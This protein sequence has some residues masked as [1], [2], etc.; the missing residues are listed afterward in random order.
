MIVLY[1][2]AHMHTRTQPRKRAHRLNAP[3]HA[4][5][6]ARTHARI[7]NAR[8][9][10][11]SYIHARAFEAAHKPAHAHS[12]TNTPPKAPQQPS[13]TDERHHNS[14]SRS[15][16]CRARLKCP[17]IDQ[18]R[19]PACF[20]CHRSRAEHGYEEK[21]SGRVQPADP[22]S[23]LGRVLT[24][25]GNSGILAQKVLE[26]LQGSRRHTLLSFT[27]GM[28]RQPNSAVC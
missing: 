11:C 1:V 19:H 8:T 17:G 22:K 16:N 5:M 18:G 9:H 7:Q 27:P 26:S 4:C 23:N 25:T 13:P 24:N 6:H 12:I 2:C 3:T 10:A 21:Q 20:L 14:S 28:L 15:N